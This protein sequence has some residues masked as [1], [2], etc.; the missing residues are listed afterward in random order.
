LKANNNDLSPVFDDETM[1]IFKSCQTQHGI[2]IKF[3]DS[4]FFEDLILKTFQPQNKQ[5]YSNVCLYVDGNIV[6]CTPENLRIGTLEEI[7]FKVGIL[8]SFCKKH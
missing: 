8:D 1:I 6:T 4:S 5:G 3:M 7:S 2:E